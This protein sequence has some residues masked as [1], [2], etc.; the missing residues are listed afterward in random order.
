MVFGAL[1][2][3]GALAWLW[4][5]RKRSTRALASPLEI[6]AQVSVGPR[7]RVVWLSAGRREMLISVSEKDVR[8]LGQWLADGSRAAETAPGPSDEPGEPRI[9][10]LATSHARLRANPSLTGLL[11]LRDQHAAAE[12]AQLDTAREGDGVP[13][14]DD[15]DSEWA[16]QLVAA[17]RRGL[18]RGATARATSEFPDG[19]SRGGMR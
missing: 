1:A 16:R 12:Q 2:G 14:D 6:L 8:V 5:R 15:E 9:G 4:V 7:A 3:L 19:G 13:A 11:R 17:T 18:P 10:R